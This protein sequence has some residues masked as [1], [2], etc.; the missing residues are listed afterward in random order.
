MENNNE[1]M[2]AVYSIYCNLIDD[3]FIPMEQNL[4][5][6]LSLESLQQ[7]NVNGIMG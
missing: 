4:N 6:D 5:T 7:N 2:Y 1:R 3:K